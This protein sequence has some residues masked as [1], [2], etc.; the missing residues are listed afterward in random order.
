MVLEK[1]ETLW[2]EAQ[3]MALMLLRKEEKRSLTA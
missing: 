3:E 2:L 1:Q